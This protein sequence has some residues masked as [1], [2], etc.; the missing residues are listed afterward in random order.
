KLSLPTISKP[1]A[2]STASRYRR[3]GAVVSERRPPF[4][5]VTINGTNVNEART[6]EKN[7]MRNTSQYALVPNWFSAT[8]PASRNEDK[9]GPRIATSMNSAARYD[10]S[11]LTCVVMYRNIDAPI[12]ASL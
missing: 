6:F 8:K 10:V 5:H 2:S 3:G 1:A 9:N 7:R 4:F 12:R 11:S